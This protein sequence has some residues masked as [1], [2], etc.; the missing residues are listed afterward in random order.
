MAVVS[1]HQVGVFVRPVNRVDGRV[2][3][4]EVRGQDNV[5]GK[6]FNA[7]DADATV[8]VQSSPLA[9]RPAA[10]VTGRLW[11]TTDAPLTLWLDTGSAWVT[12]V[13]VGPIR[14]VT[15]TATITA[16]DGTVLGDATSA[17]FNVN[18]PA[19]ST[20]A[21]RKFNIKKIDASAN[22]VTVDAD[23]TDLIDGAGTYPLAAQWESIT[24][25]SDGADWYIV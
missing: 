2:D 8:H 22:A 18:L 15:T 23:G 14:T 9:D 3:A 11:V 19:A 17:A 4:N 21:G 16:A 7:H 6:Y 20:V 5:M 12:L 25:Q 13:D 24:V 1:S 10:G